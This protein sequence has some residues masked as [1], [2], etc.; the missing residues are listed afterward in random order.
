MQKLPLAIPAELPPE[1]G[2]IE[3]QGGGW[4]V[5]PVE[6]RLALNPD[7]MDAQT[8]CRRVPAT[9]WIRIIE[10]G[11]ETGRLDIRQRQVA[12]ELASAAALGW[13]KDVDVKRAREG[14]TIIN[15]A[16]EHGGPEA[17]A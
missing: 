9:D 17:A 11:T 10:W 3:K 12:T 8:R 4:G 5:A 13:S 14:R 2:K 15:L 7:D 6:V 16:V 1:F